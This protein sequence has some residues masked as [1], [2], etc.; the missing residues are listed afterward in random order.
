M[1]WLVTGAG[2]MLATDLVAALEHRGHDVEALDRTVLDVTHPAAVDAAVAQ[3]DV[4]AN[5][6]AWTAV[7]LAEEHE[8]EAFDVNAIGPHLLAT[9]CTARGK[10]LVHVS[11][12]YV[13]D[14]R[15][16]QPYPEEAALCPSS[17]Y[18]C[19]KGAGEWAVRAAGGGHLVVRTA[20]LYGAH[21][22]CFPTT[23]HRLATERGH[24]DVVDDQVGQPTWT[25]DVAALIIEM[26]ERDAPGG[27]YHATP[28]GQTSW[29]GFARA[30]VAAG[31]MDIDLVAATTSDAFVRPAPRPA[32][33]VLGHDAIRGVGIAPIGPW[34]ERW[35]AAA[36]E[37]LA[38]V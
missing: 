10:R 9:A 15:A 1:R 33:S 13:F 22:A 27:I 4:V 35:R 17:A 3:F 30:I 36:P 20:W 14:G 34:D 21:G 26:V 19:T 5:C 6:A 28:S 7:D 11:T 12:D 8:G 23:I 31:G 2:G 16:R 25:A 18:G 29:Y 32:F 37:V 24:V 38:W